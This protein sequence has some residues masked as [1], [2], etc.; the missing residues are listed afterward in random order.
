MNVL[1]VVRVWKVRMF[2]R[3][4]MMPVHM[5]MFVTNCLRIVMLMLVMLV[6]NVF[7]MFC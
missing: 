4:R 1:P 2:M 5:V 7:M 3:R 6:V